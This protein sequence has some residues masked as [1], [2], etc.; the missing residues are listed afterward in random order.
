[1]D[2]ERARKNPF[3]AELFRDQVAIV[4]GGGTGI[5]RATAR[6]LLSLG[7][8]VAIASRKPEHFEPTRAEL[9]AETGC[10]DDAVFA[11]RCD[12]REPDEC[13]ALA[14]AVKTRF[15][16]VD[17]LVNN[18]GGQFPSAAE[19]I[20][21][22]GWEAVIRNNLNGTFYMTR[23]VAEHLML[24]AR[25]GSIVNVIANIARGFPGMAHTGAA[26]AGVDNLTK[27]LAV[28]WATHDVRV[29][30][31]APGIIES[32][33]LSQYPPEFVEACR[34]RTPQMRFGTVEEVAHAIVY[35][36]SDAAAFITGA[37]L[38]IDGGASLWGDNW[39]IPK[40]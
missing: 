3:H 11:T 33:G 36:A 19:A 40:R 14:R 27:S 31:V 24:P 25:R 18:A 4:T 8:R 20:T 2:V 10:A 1:M 38:N 7:C 35:L 21:P 13:E 32:S 23:A 16:R 28:E 17:V 9:V 12:I 30:A 6:E 39:V 5:G 15:G 29:N 22:R 34:V 26:R 37:T